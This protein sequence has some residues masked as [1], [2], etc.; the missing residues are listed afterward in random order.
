MKIRAFLSAMLLLITVAALAGEERVVTIESARMTQYIKRAPAEPK[1]EA[2]DDAEAD[3]T[4]ETEAAAEPEAAGETA[5]D[6]DGETRLEAGEGYSPPK[7]KSESWGE[8]MIL[9]SGEVVI[10]V[11]EGSSKSTI[12]A[13]EIVYDKG[14]DTLEARGNVTYEHS[15]GKSGSERFTGEALL[16]DI[17]KEEG[18]FLKGIVTQDSGKKDSDPYIIHSEVTG[19]DSSTTMAFKNGVLTTCDEEEPHWSINASRI[20]LLPGN[21][22][23]ILNGVFFIGPLPVFYI[24]FFYY[25]GDEMIFHPVFGYRNREGYFVQTT[26]YLMGRK[27]LPVKDS[28]T[29]SSF[30]DFLQG[31]VLKEQK[32][33]GLFFR[34]QK[35]D[36]KDLDPDYLK[37]MV[38]GY[39]SLGAMI[40]LDGSFS[41]NGYFKTISFLLSAGFSRTLYEPSSGLGFSTYDDQGKEHWNSGIFFGNEVPF[42]YRTKLSVQMDKKPFTLSMSMPLVSD[43]EYQDDFLDRSEDLNWFKLLT[44]KEELAKDEND[45]DETSYSWNING[46]INPDMSATSPWLK[47]FSVSSISG[48]MTFNSKTNSTLTGQELLYS[49]ERKFYYP[50]IIKPELKLSIAGTILTSADTSSKK[51]VEGIDTGSLVN[52][53]TNLPEQ[54]PEVKPEAIEDEKESSETTEGDGTAE[55]VEAPDAVSPTQDE[56]K[57]GIERFVPSPGNVTKT[58]GGR[59][60]SEYSITWGL[61]P[62]FVHETR[63]DSTEWEESSDIDWSN[64]SSLYYQVKS[65]ARLKGEYSWDSDMFTIST[66]LNFTGTYQE[67]PWLSDGVYNTDAKKNKVYL[68]DYESSVYT[69]KNNDTVKYV[70]FNRSE[71]FKPIS[72]SWNFTGDIVKTEFTGT[73]DDPDWEQKTFEWDEDYIDTHTAVSTLG[74]AIGPYEQKFTLTSNL[75]PLL[76]SYGGNMQFSWFFG[77]LTM[78]SKLYEKEDAAENREWLW[79]PLKAVFSW[80]FP[81]DLSFSQEYTY[82]IEDSKSTRLNF[83]GSFKSL[84]AYYTLTDTVPYDFVEGEGWVLKNTGQEFVPTAAGM[85]FNNGS[86]PLNLYQWDNRVA[87]Q[88]KVV[89][90]L[91]FNLLKLTDSSFTFSPSLTL[92]IFEFLDLTFSSTSGNEVIA[93]YFQDWMDL[94]TPLPGETNIFKDLFKSVNFFDEQGRK[95]SG[96]KLKSL[97]FELT[98]YLHDWTMNFKTSIKPELKEDGG[99]Y[100]YEFVPTVTFMVQWKPISDIKTTVKSE[101]NVFSLNTT[102]DEDDDDDDD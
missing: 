58:V 26:T 49:P 66:V 20:W 68:S 43:P 101:E 30:S 13:D 34:N 45:S 50:E 90:N 60:G 21:E 92:K 47:T 32:R 76:E 77:S 70:P 37:L 95:E 19:R 36:A 5:A 18:V 94:P 41:T 52:P 24:P 14:R 82:D 33:E 86:R 79:D 42:R 73:A 48:V 100:S 25:P 78:S 99:R 57:D 98:H 39:S 69:V 44:D 81:Y 102:D 71:L 59:K 85:A 63:Y 80:K 17:K 54:K 2:G 35:E 46:S 23:A 72:L 61:D 75:P 93:R 6:D 28:K 22:I 8:E 96:F 83:T 91:E 7:D 1:T 87:L 64:Y 65:T 4:G 88:L 62:S 29:G 74:V 12:S 9:F 97:N 67:H 10:V 56:F 16:F 55:A 15:T 3:V 53:Y 51:S 27:P 40:G 31:D 11:T 38:D 89:S 84:S